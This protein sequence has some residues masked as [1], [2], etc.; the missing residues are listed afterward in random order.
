MSA[1]TSIYTFAR[2]LRIKAGIKHATVINVKLITKDKIK[3]E[4]LNELL[5]KFNTTVQTVSN[6]RINNDAKIITINEHAIEYENDF[7][8]SSLEKQKL[9]SDLKHFEMEVK[10]SETIL[11]NKSFVAKAPK[12]KVI[13]EKNKLQQYK[14]QY[15]KI[16]A[17]LKKN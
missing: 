14:D 1:F 17:A 16:A 2:D 13:L 9:E 5:Q 7:L 12:E 8:D 10:R 3:K 4:E 6:K 15:Q 11:A